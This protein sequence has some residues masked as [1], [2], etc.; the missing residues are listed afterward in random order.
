M[1]DKPRDEELKD[2]QKTT[3]EDVKGHGVD[4]ED[5]GEVGVFNVNCGC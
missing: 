2:S 4:E 1:A 5:D 3:E